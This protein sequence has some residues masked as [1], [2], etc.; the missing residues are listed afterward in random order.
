MGIERKGLFLKICLRFILRSSGLA[1]R[2]FRILEFRFLGV[3][4]R[5]VGVSCK[6]GGMILK[7]EENLFYEDFGLEMGSIVERFVGISVLVFGLNFVLYF[8]VV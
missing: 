4:M 3:V 8:L 5:E 1:G 2:I 6:L 7:V